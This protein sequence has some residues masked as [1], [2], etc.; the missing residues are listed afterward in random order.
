MA[1]FRITRPYT[2]PKEEVRAAAEGFAED[3]AR[4]YGV[5]SRWQGDSVK[6]SGAGVDG[7]LAFHDGLID[8]SVKLGLLTSMFEGKLR[9]EVERYL[10]EHIS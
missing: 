1:G 2:M 5:K 4:E 10:D 6:I 8:V 9:R 3:L 7:Q